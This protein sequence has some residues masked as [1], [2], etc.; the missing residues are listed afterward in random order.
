[1]K[2]WWKNETIQAF[3]ERTQCIIEQ[4]SNVKLEQI[5]VNVCIVILI[6]EYYFYFVCFQQKAIVIVDHCCFYTRFSK[7]K[8]GLL[9]WGMSA[10]RPVLFTV[11]NYFCMQLLHFSRGFDQ[12]FTNAL[13]SSFVIRCFVIKHFWW[14]YGP[15]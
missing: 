9:D 4:Y 3:Q 10:G 1:M 15:L 6:Q 7:R 8:I 13:S 14:N 12:T 11:N 2:Q 5:G